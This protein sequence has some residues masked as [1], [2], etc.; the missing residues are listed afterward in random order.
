[1]DVLSKRF[2][3]CP[4][5]QVLCA[6]TPKRNSAV[7]SL[8]YYSIGTKINKLSLPFNCFFGLLA[9]SN[10]NCVDA[11]ALSVWYVALTLQVPVIANFYFKAKAFAVFSVNTLVTLFQLAKKG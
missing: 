4:A 6:P 5:I 7:Q 1:M 2:V 8:Y 3:F 9:F 10:V 11:N